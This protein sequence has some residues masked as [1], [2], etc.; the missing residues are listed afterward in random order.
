MKIEISNY[1]PPPPRP[2]P[3]QRPPRKFRRVLI[4]SAILLGSFC[5]SLAR[6]NHHEIARMI[7]QHDSK[8]TSSASAATGKAPVPHDGQQTVQAP[9]PSVFQ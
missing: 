4:M 9:P 2:S 7:S 5:V 6:L 8:A 1:T 3:P